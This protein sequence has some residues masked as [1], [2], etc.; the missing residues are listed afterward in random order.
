MPTDFTTERYGRLRKSSSGI[1]P[2]DNQPPEGEEKNLFAASLDFA[3]E[4]APLGPEHRPRSLKELGVRSGIIEDLALKLLYTAGPFSVYDMGRKMRVSYDVANEVFNKMRAGLLCQVTG[5]KGNVA[6][7]A[8]TSQGRSR[9]LELLTASQY[10]GPAPVSLTSYV[11]QVRKQSV[12]HAVVHREDVERAFA[13]MVLENKTL[14][15]IG[16]AL[17]SGASI[18]LHGPAGVGKSAIAETM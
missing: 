10:S 11:E 13:H 6:E 8:I 1:R 9:A 12:R 3:S 17:N 18:F 14:W 16:I 2:A 4:A 7:I 5:M 15:Q